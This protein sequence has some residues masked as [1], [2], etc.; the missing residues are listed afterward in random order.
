MG[1]A[2]DHAV[3]LV[4]RGPAPVTTWAP[5][6]AQDADADLVVRVSA[7]LD[8]HDPML[9][10]AMRRGSDLD[11]MLAGHKAPREHAFA[12]KARRA[13]EV[14][15]REDGPRVAAL[16]FEGWDTHFAEGALGGRLS[17]LLGQ[18]DDALGALKAGLGPAWEETVTLVVTEFGRTVRI[19]GTRGTD[20]GTGTVAL[21]AGGALARGPAVM[22]RWPGLSRLHDDRDL[23][24]TTDLRAALKGVLGE[25]MG[26]SAR[27]LEGSVFPDSAGVRPLTN[28]MG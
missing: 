27:A 21:M 22:G 26:V 5:G 13:G 28:L 24:P 15:A 1:L 16:G 10:D 6:G 11:A 25:H 2:I 4:L 12:L 8:A 3:P 20:H 7:L 19:N 9:A 18:L 14:L 23:M 17:R